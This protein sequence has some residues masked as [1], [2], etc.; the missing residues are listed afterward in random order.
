MSKFVI[1]DDYSFNHSF[2]FIFKITVNNYN[3]DGKIIK[4]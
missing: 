1:D 3:F 4:S 2:N